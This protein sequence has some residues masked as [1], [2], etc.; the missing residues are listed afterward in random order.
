MTA[1]RVLINALEHVLH[2]FSIRFLTCKV[3]TRMLKF[4]FRRYGLQRIYIVNRDTFALNIKNGALWLVALHGIWK[5][6][7]L[8]TVRSVPYFIILQN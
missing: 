5:V 6:S 4:E 2:L 1:E 3:V 8:V 7:H